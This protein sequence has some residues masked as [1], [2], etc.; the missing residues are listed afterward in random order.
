MSFI[1]PVLAVSTSS[2]PHEDAKKLIAGDNS[3]IVRPNSEYG[4]FVRVLQDY[5][6]HTD[7]LEK[8]HEDEFSEHFINLVTHARDLGCGWL[9]LDQDADEYPYLPTFD[10]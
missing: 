5:N 10:W 8:A 7:M 2:I 6:E 1:E 9:L 4:W 3:F